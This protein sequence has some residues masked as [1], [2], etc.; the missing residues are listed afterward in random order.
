MRRSVRPIRSQPDQAIKDAVL[1][2]VAMQ[3]RVARLLPQTGH[4]PVPGARQGVKPG[5]AEVAQVGQDQ[6][7]GRHVRQEPTGGDFLVLLGIG[8]VL[9]M[10]PLLQAQVEDT[11][12][13]AGQQRRGTAR[14]GPQGGQDAR[15]RVQGGLVQGNHG[16][17]KGSE[18]VVSIAGQ[19][20][21]EQAR[22]LSEELDERLAAG[23]VQ[24]LIDGLIGDGNAWIVPQAVA[25]E[26]TPDGAA[27]GGPL[28]DTD[29][30]GGPEQQG[31]QHAGPTGA[32][33]VSIGG[34]KVG[35]QA[36]Q[37]LL[38]V[39]EEVVSGWQRGCGRNWVVKIKLM[40]TW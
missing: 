31:G 37:E 33:G 38:D 13:F 24:A 15:N 9:D 11:A 17:G 20:A 23:L 12:E 22:N 6:T 8:L 27:A 5:E 40:H 3:D 36:L 16:G 25:G 2:V 21:L 26:Q 14:Q 39:A 1:I 18:G 30:Q 4:P 28:E 32:G 10:T 7:P 35:E 29:E 34:H 19:A